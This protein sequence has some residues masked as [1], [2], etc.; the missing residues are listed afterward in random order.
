MT[1]VD[2]TI[3]SLILSIVGNICFIWYIRKLLGKLLF[4]SEN[5]GDLVQLIKAYSL[6]LKAINDMELYYGD[7]TIMFLIKH[8]KSLLLLLEEY[9][10]VY[11]I[12]NPIEFI[13]TEQDEQEYDKEKTGE[14]TFREADVFYGGS[15]GSNS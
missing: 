3:L 4:I 11:E 5:L 8:T 6:H 10:D 2:W 13:E 7:E 15:R 14:K 12:T 1:L 9:E